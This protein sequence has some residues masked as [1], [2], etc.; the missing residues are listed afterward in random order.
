M[1]VNI[2]PAVD[3]DVSM[4][5]CHDWRGVVVYLGASGHRE[6]R[7]AQEREDVFVRLHFFPFPGL[8]F[9]AW[10]FSAAS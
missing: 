10:F 9:D 3:I 4:G 1:D 7:D 6:Q 5:P 2:N 8:M